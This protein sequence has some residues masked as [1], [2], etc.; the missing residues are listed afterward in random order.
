M[1]KERERHLWNS[2]QCIKI[3]LC[4]F[5]YTGKLVTRGLILSR[6]LG[7]VFGKLKKYGHAMEMVDKERTTVLQTLFFFAVGRK[8]EK[9][10]WIF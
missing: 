6:S 5:F 3:C 4:C 7:I 8:E 1:F 9:A 10:I 2:E